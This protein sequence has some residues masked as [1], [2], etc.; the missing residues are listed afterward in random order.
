MKWPTLTLNKD[1]DPLVM[2][3]SS[4]IALAVLLALVQL[5]H[6][7]NLPIWISAFGLG[8]IS[9]RVYARG[10]PTDKRW[11]YIFSSPTITI[12][13]L[14]G[15][16]L[17]RLHYGYFLGR[18]P[19]VA[20]LFLLI[21]LKFGEYRRSADA[22][23]LIG[24][25]CV[26]L[27]TQYFYSQSILSAVVTL[28]AVFALGHALAVLRDPTHPLAKKPQLRLV[29]KLLLQGLPIALILFVLFPRLP[30]PLWSIPDD[31]V[32][33]TGLSDTMRPGDIGTLSQSNEV[34]FRVEFNTSPPPPEA[35][36][37]RGPVL[38][39]F[40]GFAWTP[41]NTI[42]E[43][44]PANASPAALE[45][46]VMLQPH[47][48]NWLFALDQAVSIP[49]KDGSLTPPGQASN[50]AT[51]T[52]SG[53][54]LAKEPITRV[55]RYTQR[56]SLTTQFQSPL[57]PSAAEL[58]FPSNM[59]RTEQLAQTLLT[60]SSS[61]RDY[62]NRVMQ[63]FNRLDFRYTLQPGLLGNNPVDEFLFDTQQGFCEHYSSAF[64][65]MMRAAGI[66]ARVVTGY[67]GG[68]MNED[69]MIVRQ[70]DAHAWSEV[71]IDGRWQRFDPTAAVAPERV[72][73]GVRAALPESDL[74]GFSDINSYSW[75]KNM[76]LAWDSVNHNWQRMVVDYNN[77]SQE[78]LF[79]KIGLPSLA[80]WQ[81][82]ALIL[83][84]AG[85]WC[86]W[87][88]RSPLQRRN[89]PLLPA[90]RVWKKFESLLG[91]H[92]VEREPSE[93]PS[94]FLDRACEE[95][96]DWSDDIKK[97]GTALLSAR[98]AAMDL[99]VASQKATEASKQIKHLHQR[100]K[101]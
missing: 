2:D 29:G 14:I 19:C 33:K 37:W 18:D 45:Y 4:L 91:A 64:T 20:F 71:H 88:L 65:M 44:Y 26:L 6:V 93:T 69:Y 50:F 89:T 28:P 22:T 23:L 17:I 55:T 24:L 56:S 41:D 42:T 75:T 16:G 54:L 83:C 79:K 8:V 7:L 36:Y 80:I 101:T 58:N 5:P 15:A 13:A 87:M 63:R 96:S 21:S 95:L 46:T 47:K 31:A 94:A 72:E 61:P 3:S 57:R 62:A 27:L 1:N 52:T 90:D 30:G 70:S 74:S 49:A 78:N 38:T 100:I 81:I 86:L 98:F 10:T 66:P 9:L 85:L 68:E 12:V 35:R 40:D 99:S 82:T 53:Q 73:R 32:G 97:I 48:Q 39:R 60:Q 77:R 51:L 11:K 92:G 84:I 76:G 43:A 25:A 59:P 34:A 67:L